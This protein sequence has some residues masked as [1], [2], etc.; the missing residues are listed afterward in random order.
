MIHEGAARDSVVSSPARRP[1]RRRTP[2]TPS[3]R[4][5]PEDCLNTEVCCA[6]QNGASCAD[7]CP[8][9]GALLCHT[10]ADCDDQCIV[11]DYQIIGPTDVCGVPDCPRV[12]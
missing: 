5:G 2:S 11:C 7:D 9:I 6:T 4:V 8:A 10:D 1:C 12:F 3:P